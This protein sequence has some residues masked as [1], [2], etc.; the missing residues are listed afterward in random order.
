[1]SVFTQNV[2]HAMARVLVPMAGPPTFVGSGVQSVVTIS[3]TTT[4][5]TLQD[6]IGAGESLV[7]LG[8][9]ANV[10]GPT[11]GPRYTRPDASTVDVTSQLDG[12]GFGS[13]FSIA[14]LRIPRAV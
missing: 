1:M 5:V 9:E 11:D 12:T 8:Q 10:P 14:V 2:I 6:P 13:D 3:P 7:L 4:R